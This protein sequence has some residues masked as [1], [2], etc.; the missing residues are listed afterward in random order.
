VES[1]CCWRG[2]RWIYSQEL[3]ET[4][5]RCFESSYDRDN[6]PLHLEGS[7]YLL[8]IHFQIEDSYLNDIVIKPKIFKPIPYNPLKQNLS[9]FGNYQTAFSKVLPRSETCNP[10]VSCS[11]HSAILCTGSSQMPC[12][13]M[14]NANLEIL[15][16][17]CP[18]T[19]LEY[20]PKL[21]ELKHEELKKDDG[22]I[23]K[24]TSKAQLYENFYLLTKND[25]NLEL[26]KEFNYETVVKKTKSGKEQTVFVCGEDGFDKEFL[27]SC[28]LLDHLRM[29]NGI[30]PNQCRFCGK[31]FTQKSNLT[32]HLKVHQKPDL[33]DRKRYPC[34]RC[35]A[36]Y[37]E[38]YN[39]KKH[40]EKY[41]RGESFNQVM[42]ESQ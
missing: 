27:R 38:R 15:N 33:S 13:E 26:L 9:A 17:F 21:I 34:P 14:T 35:P 5:R 41:H 25:I 4:I 8:L 32:K 20:L 40:F 10:H 29:H 30:K 23:E 11:D 3:Y 18:E 7:S 28:N 42:D 19:L 22:M 16:S 24:L 2:Y 36:A 12:P 37:T 31:T 39:L 1:T 6:L